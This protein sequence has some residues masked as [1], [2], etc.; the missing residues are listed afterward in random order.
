MAQPSRRRGRLASPR[1]CRS[2]SSLA[3]LP[4]LSHSHIACVAFALAILCS[5]FQ[6]SLSALSFLLLSF[7]FLG[8]DARLRLSLF[9]RAGRRCSCTPRA[10]LVKFRRGV[11][12]IICAIARSSHVRS[13]NRPLLKMSPVHFHARVCIGSLAL[14]VH[15]IACACFDH[16][17]RSA[18]PVGTSRP[19]FSLSRFRHVVV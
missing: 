12:T 17:A 5:L 19:R 16:R 7:S 4:S 8:V 15:R 2:S 1:A 14:A 6:L 3:V 13:L 9:R 18:G 11:R 10:H